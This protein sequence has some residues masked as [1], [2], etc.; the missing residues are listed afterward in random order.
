MHVKVGVLGLPPGS[1]AP[2]QNFEHFY[3]NIFK[4]REAENLIEGAAAMNETGALT[5]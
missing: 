2:L 5:I 4:N 3:F 1:I